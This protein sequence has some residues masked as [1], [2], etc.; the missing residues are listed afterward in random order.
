MR[1]AYHDPVTHPVARLWR[2]LPEPSTRAL[3]R[4]AIASLVSQAGIVVTGG[5][6]R[7]TGSGLGCPTFPRCTEDSLVNTPEHGLHGYI[8]FGNRLLTFVLAAIALATLLAVL[9]TLAGPR[10]RRDLLPLAVVLLLGIPAQ[11]MI[12]GITV[13]TRLNPWV[14]MLHFMCSAVLVGLATALLRRVSEPAVGPVRAVGSPWLRRLATIVVGVAYATVYAGTVVTGTGPHAGDPSSPRT[15]L[16]LEAVTQVHADLVFLLLGT[17]LGLWFA[18][19]ALGSPGRTSRAAGT[20]LALEL[21]QGTIGYTQV[22]TGVPVLLVGLHML[23][24]TLIV[25]AA[26]DAWLSTRT[27]DAPTGQPTAQP[28]GE[29][30]RSTL[31]VARTAV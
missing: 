29:P 4:L 22:F 23:G 13:L 24:A 20:L 30:A 8:E 6:V 27:F 9:R 19:R 31:P 16:D 12:G 7:L 3:R 2:R 25:I 10:P 15:G 5:A 1:P 18:A 14:V 17:T 26:V 28:T 21:A 11:A